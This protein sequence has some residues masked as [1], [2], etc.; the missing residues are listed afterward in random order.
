MM[1]GKYDEK[2]LYGDSGNLSKVSTIT[3]YLFLLPCILVVL[4]FTIALTPFRIIDI[5]AKSLDAR[6]GCG[7]HAPVSVP[8]LTPPTDEHPKG[9]FRG[10][11]S[12]GWY[13]GD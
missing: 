12:W 13:F 9:K 7:S 11:G 3:L 6:T 8:S 2:D 10:C 1:N 4:T 5:D